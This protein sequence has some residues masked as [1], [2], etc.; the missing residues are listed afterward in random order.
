MF[1]TLF[2][3]YLFIHEP[4]VAFDIFLSFHFWGSSPTR[5]VLV[6]QYPKDL[7]DKYLCTA[8]NLIYTTNLIIVHAVTGDSGNIRKH[9]EI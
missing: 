4:P 5:S 8:F 7:A 2:L 1:F 9:P 3:F 6:C